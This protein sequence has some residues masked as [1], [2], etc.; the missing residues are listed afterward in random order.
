MIFLVQKKFN[1][2]FANIKLTATLKSLN[3]E[4][5][6]LPHCEASKIAMQGLTATVNRQDG[7]IQSLTKQVL[8]LESTFHE[9][10][11]QNLIV[12][13]TSDL[14]KLGLDKLKQYSRRVC[15]V[16]SGEKLPQNKT[17]EKTEE[18][19]TKVREIFTQEFGVNKDDFDYELDKA[20]NQL[21]RID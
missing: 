4:T 1:A 17:S 18:T 5:V 6:A 21:N 8:Y 19:E 12:T 10:Q 13:N 9:I 11:S 16:I 20:A 3:S 2:R 14:L 15:L 7:K